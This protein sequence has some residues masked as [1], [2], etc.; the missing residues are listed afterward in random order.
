MKVIEAVD[1]FCGGGGTSEGFVNAGAKVVLA[2]DFWDQALKIHE[3]NHPDIET[4][5]MELG[6]S[7]TLAASFIRSRLTKGAHFH[8]HGSPP[9]QALSNASRTNSSEGMNMVL[10]FLKLVKYMKPDS[11]SM[12]NVVPLGKHLREMNIP[13]QIVN[14]ADYGVPQARKRVF[15]G[16]GWSLTPTHSEDKWVGV[17]DALPHLIDELT[18]SHRVVSRRRKAH[19]EPQSYS[20]SDPSHTITRLPHILENL[21]MD[22]GRSSAKT[23]GVNPAT[24]KKEGGSGFLSKSVRKPSYTIMSSPKNLVDLTNDNVRKVRSLTLAESATLQGWPDMKLDRSMTKKNQWV[25][26]GNM[27]CP[28]VAEAII[29]G[30]DID[31]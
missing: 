17:I 5:Q 16:E 13:Y 24:G 23:S 26:V 14:A 4:A 15:A 30:I 31:C 3:L 20:G 12:E 1:L 6:G 29:R 21:H 18:P 11:W 9:C 19:E 8:L 28:P 2:V 25:V 7:I 27:V 10:W 22:A